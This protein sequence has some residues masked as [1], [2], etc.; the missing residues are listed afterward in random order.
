MPDNW[1]WD[2]LP[3]IV[4]QLARRPGHKAVRVALARLIVDGLGREVGAIDHMAYWAPARSRVEAL[5]LQPSSTANGSACE[6]RR[7]NPGDRAAAVPLREGAYFITQRRA[8]RDALAAAG[9]AARIDAV[10][11]RLPGL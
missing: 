9:I 5:F 10:V 7:C 4:T 1:R 6:W 11:A 2:T 3:G 8:I